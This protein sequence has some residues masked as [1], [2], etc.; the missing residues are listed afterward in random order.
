MAKIL[1]SKTCGLCYG[2]NRAISTT[3]D[4]V[5]RENNVVLFKEIL[6]NRNVLNEL[7]KDGAIIKENLN[8]ISAD[9]FVIIRAHG[10]PKKTYD[11]F[12]E[13]GIRYIDCTCPNVKAINLLVQRK[14]SEGYK[15]IIIGKYGFSG[16]SMHPEV[17]GTSGWCS[18][19][20]LL[21]E[22]SEIENLDLSYDK[23]YLVV[24][25][26]FS[27]EKAE[28]MIELI[29]ILME[30]NGKDFEYKNTICDAQKNINIDSKKLVKLVDKMIVI[31]GKSSSNTKE[32]FK[33]MSGIKPSFH[34]E[35]VNEVE[36]LITEGILKKEDTIGLTAGASTMLEDIQKVKK[37][38]ESRLS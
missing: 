9:D 17:A 14:D 7:A 38:I 16:K 33:V 31:G 11:Y 18:N 13:N 8:D 20:I 24:Q 37:L 34:V 3:R 27:R 22:E 28:K 4:V 15:I 1:I 32:L 26:T 25:T 30:E 12:N 36:F 21:E 35:S 23:Y 6:H 29:K 10:E 5:K 2:S 19:P